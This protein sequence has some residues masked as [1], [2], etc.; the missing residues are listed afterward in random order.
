MVVIRG[1]PGK[2]GCAAAARPLPEIPVPSPE[3]EPQAPVEIPPPTPEAQPQAVPE[4]PP[5]VPEVPPP[6]PPEIP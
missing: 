1:N 4:M 3:L 5:L 6:P 2:P